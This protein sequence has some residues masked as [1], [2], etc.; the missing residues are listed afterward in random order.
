MYLE[1]K[2][3]REQERGRRYITGNFFR[4]GSEIVEI[5]EKK[6]EEEK[7]FHNLTQWEEEIAQ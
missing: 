7:R 5:Y 4:Q 6:E 1:A 3:F 2:G